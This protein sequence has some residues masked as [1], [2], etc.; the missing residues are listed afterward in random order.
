MTS[1]VKVEPLN[2][3]LDPPGAELTPYVYAKRRSSGCRSSASPSTAIIGAGG[4][5]LVM[6]VLLMGWTLFQALRRFARAR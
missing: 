5:K 1:G 2:V 4:V 6:V 3:A